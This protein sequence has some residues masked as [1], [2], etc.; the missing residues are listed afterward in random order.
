MVLRGTV[1]PFVMA[2]PYYPTGHKRL[3]GYAASL[4]FL[5]GISLS[6]GG[7]V[8][9]RE[10]EENYRGYRSTQAFWGEKMNLSDVIEI[11]EKIH[12]KDVGE[13]GYCDLEG[14]IEDIVGIE[15]DINPCMGRSDRIGNHALSPAFNQGGPGPRG[16]RGAG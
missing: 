11:W 6:S 5:G 3:L 12:V 2:G 10:D 15:N 14:A 9:I 1:A 7:G 13:L 8:Y 16:G 4:S